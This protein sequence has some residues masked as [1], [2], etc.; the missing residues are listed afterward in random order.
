[1]SFNA[2]TYDN[3]EYNTRLERDVSVLSY[4]LDSSKFAHCNKCF[5]N[6]GL[7][8][9]T[10]VSHVNG[11]LVDLESN[12]IGID[13]EASKCPSM[14]YLPNSQDSAIG[15]DYY[16][17]RCTNVVDTTKSHLPSCQLYSTPYVPYPPTMQPYKCPAR[18]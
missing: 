4:N 2:L 13:R 18:R 7:V 10:A 9:G 1:M 15:A 6:L 8:G 14:K 16:H 17:P 12:L 3:C 5:N 11:N